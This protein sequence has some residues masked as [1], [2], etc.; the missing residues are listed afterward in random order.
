MDQCRFGTPYQKATGILATSSMYASLGRRCTCSEPH[1]RREGAATTRA[2]EYPLRLCQEFARISVVHAKMT[3]PRDAGGCVSNCGSASEG[4]VRDSRSVQRFVSH[5]W[6]THLAESLPW[7]VARAYRFK[8]PNHINI[9][10]S[11]ALRTLMAVAPMNSRLVV[12]QDSMVTLGASAKGR[13]SGAP[14][15]RILRQSMAL[16]V[17][18]NLYPTGV[19]CPTWALRGAYSPH[20]RLYIPASCI[21]QCRCRC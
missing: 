4:E 21:R 16:Q 2:S 12:F 9:L 8:R 6:S 19:H 15:N 14:L 1:E 20:G 10:E 18:K 3:L 13:S 17:G 11:H 5:L 7:K